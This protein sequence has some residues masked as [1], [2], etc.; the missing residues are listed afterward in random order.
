M[1]K[2]KYKFYLLLSS[3]IL[4]IAIFVGLFFMDFDDFFPEDISFI[5]QNPSCDL[6]EKSCEINLGKNQKIS[7]SISPKSIPLMKT[8]D[9]KVK[10]QNLNLEDLKLKIYATNMD[11]GIFK[12]KFKKISQ[13]TFLAKQMLPTCIIGNMIWNADISSSSLKNGARFTFKTK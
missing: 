4:I 6:R 3:Q 5:N 8:L 10:T 13:N 12:K 11:M 9:F 2:S 1:K 7:L